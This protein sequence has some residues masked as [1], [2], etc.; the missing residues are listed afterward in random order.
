MVG[1]RAFTTSD[2]TGLHHL[3]RLRNWS[4]CRAKPPQKLRWT[5]AGR[6][7]AIGAMEIAPGTLGGWAPHAGLAWSADDM[8]RWIWRG[9]RAP[10]S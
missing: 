2:V 9:Q 10:W 7:A 3:A 6:L 4:L 8:G 5:N 1:Q